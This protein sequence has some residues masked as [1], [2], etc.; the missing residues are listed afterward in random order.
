M[1]PK[2]LIYLTLH[3]FAP[4]IYFFGH[5]AIQYVRGNNLME[6]AVDILCIIAIYS[7]LLGIIWSLLIDKLDQAIK[8]DEENN[9]V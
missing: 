9:G 8:A 5:L 6:A 3:V 4:C 1:K 7:I 2:K